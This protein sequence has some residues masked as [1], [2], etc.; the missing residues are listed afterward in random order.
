MAPS[1]VNQFHPDL[2]HVE[3]ISRILKLPIV[4]D[5]TQI[6]GNVYNRI[7]RSNYLMN[8]GL[9]TAERSFMVATTL[10]TPAIKV[11]NGPISAIDHLLCKGMDVVEE[12]VPA[13]H[14]TPSQMYSS[15]KDYMNCKI[16]PV[17]SGAESMTQIGSIVANATAERLNDALTNVEKHIDDY[18][19]DDP[20][21]KVDTV[22][23]TTNVNNTTRTII[24][25]DRCIRKIMKM[26][27]HLGK[28]FGDIMTLILTDPEEALKKLCDWMRHTMS[29]EKDK[30]I[31]DTL[32]QSFVLLLNDIRDRVQK[33]AQEIS[34]TMQNRVKEISVTIENRVKEMVST[35]QKRGQEI[36]VTIQH[37]T[38]EIVVTIQHRMQ[39]ITFIIHHRANE[40]V[41]TISMFP[42]L[43]YAKIHPLI[44]QSKRFIKNFKK[45][46]MPV[47][48]LLE[49]IFF[50]VSCKVN[51]IAW[52]IHDY[53]RYSIG[54]FF[55]WLTY[56]NMLV[57]ALMNILN[58]P[59]KVYP[60]GDP[61]IKWI[62]KKDSDIADL[63][64][65]ITQTLVGERLTCKQIQGQYHQQNGI[66]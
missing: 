21:N 8:W 32:Q 4:E 23:A 19:P 47:A 39:E 51:N 28:N 11:F 52:T 50:Y 59:R 57:K 42:V 58:I 65:K 16:I 49:R 33:R 5:G 46:L 27:I 17:L 7:K 20:S 45:H 10:A 12:K 9:G 14:L 56:L 3:S 15:A 44:L 35:M 25:S 6:A 31:A 29:P 62:S 24:L 43:I 36:A 13:V 60:S 37:R 55:N 1:T 34:A 26:L 2:L 63:L 38:H 64:K 30:I 61:M 48:I 40:I 66:E 41:D 53:L 18:L 54:R 22:D